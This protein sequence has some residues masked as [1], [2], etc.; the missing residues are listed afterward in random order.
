MVIV[1]QAETRPDKHPWVS[2]LLGRMSKKQVAECP[3]G[4]YRVVP[5][6]ACA[7]SCRIDPC[8]V[9]DLLHRPTAHAEAC[10]AASRALSGAQ[11]HNYLSVLAFPA[12][13]VWTVAS[14]RFVRGLRG[15]S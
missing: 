6:I 8:I 12:D 1:S 10:C 5:S 13:A 4:R 11:A 15:A 3:P 14:P 2:K 7:G 9:G